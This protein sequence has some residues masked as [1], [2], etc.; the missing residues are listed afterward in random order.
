MEKIRWKMNKAVFLDRDG[1]LIKEV[2]YLSDISQL[3]IY[4]FSFDAVKVLN[5]LGYKVIIITNQS[6]VARG[7]FNEEFVKK[8]NNT[9]ID[10]FK[11][12]G[13]I[14]HDAFYCPHHPDDN[15]NCRKPE[16]GMLLQAQKKYNIDFSKSFIIGDSFKDSET[17]LNAGVFPIQVITGHGK[18]F[19]KSDFFITENIYTA[20]LLIKNLG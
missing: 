5:N 8:V 12:K 17:G 4:D 1:T 15:C 14:I 11:N 10:S 3:Q 2:N 9:L 18:N 13:A 19:I 7:Y 6:G 20:T 16:I